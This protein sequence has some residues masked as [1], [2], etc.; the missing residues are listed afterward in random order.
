MF[1]ITLANLA[2]GLSNGF[3]RKFI[4]LVNEWEYTRSITPNERLPMLWWDVLELRGVELVGTCSLRH[5]TSGEWKRHGDCVP[6]LSIE[7]HVTNKA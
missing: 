1:S 6:F 5:S 2:S 3:M 7:D 4:Q